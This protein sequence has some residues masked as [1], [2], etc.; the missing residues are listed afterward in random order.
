MPG[1]NATSWFALFAPAKT[2]KDIVSKLEADVRNMLND[3]G[4]QQKALDQGATADFKD[5]LAL[6]AMVKSDWDMWA[7]IVKEANIKAE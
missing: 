7:K 5:S 6:A 1:V 4:F 3:P 2:P